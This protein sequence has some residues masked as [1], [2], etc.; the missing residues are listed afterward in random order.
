MGYC[1][2][3]GALINE[4]ESFCSSCGQKCSGTN[5]QNTVQ[6]NVKK[7][8][9]SHKES[10][11]NTKSIEEKIKNIDFKG[12]GQ[13]IVSF[14]KNIDFKG[15]IQKIKNIDFNSILEKMKKMDRKKAIPVAAGVGGGL[16]ILV[17][18]LN[19]T[20]WSP[21]NKIFNGFVKLQSA[22]KLKSTIT[23]TGEDLFGYTEIAKVLDDE[24]TVEIKTYSDISNGRVNYEMKIKADN[25][26]FVEFNVG[27]V[28]GES[29]FDFPKAS[30]DYYSLML[31]D[32]SYTV[33]EKIINAEFVKENMKVLQSGEYKKIFKDEIK[34]HLDKDGSKTVLEFKQT[35]LYEL[36]AD[37]YEEASNDEKLAKKMYKETINIIEDLDKNKKD[38]KKVGSDFVECQIEELVDTYED[39]DEDDFIK[40][41]ES[42]MKYFE[43]YYRNQAERDNETEI[44]CVFNFGMFNSIDSMDITID[45]GYDETEL[46]V[47]FGKGASKP[48][49]SKKKA[50][51]FI[52]DSKESEDIIESLIEEMKKNDLINE[53]IE[54]ELDDNSDYENELE[55]VIEYR[56]ESIGTVLKNLIDIAN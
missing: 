37:L 32:A 31:L 28:E 14:F 16:I 56:L 20:I 7:V 6:N 47:D 12:I 29:Y 48:K 18:L 50:E 38:F 51:K 42:N 5:N 10:K 40:E 19:L 21:T 49:Y 11:I 55:E 34:K 44:E 9:Q 23:I 53:T 2:K 17:I 15:I 1:E 46:T 8:N 39:M 26:D 36:Y 24:G 27:H 3:C 25:D 41:F 33:D 54:D 43:E 52:V 35:D 4:G 22:D 13:K 30:K 45:D